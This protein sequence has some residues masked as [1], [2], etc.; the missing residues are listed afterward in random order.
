MK[1]RSLLAS[2]FLIIATTASAKTIVVSDIDDTLKNAHVLNT[3]DMVKN[4]VFTNDQFLGINWVYNQLSLS[5]PEM[6]FFYVSSAPQQIMQE[7]HEDFIRGNKF[8]RGGVYLKTDFFSSDF[9]LVKIRQILKQELPSDVIFVGDNGEI[10]TLVYE[11]LRTEFPT[12]KFTTYIHLAYYSKS[13]KET[14]K[15][16][17]AGQIGFATSLDL[18]LQLYQQNLIPQNYLQGFLDTF[19]GVYLKQNENDVRLAIANWMDCR[20]FSWTVN[21]SVFAESML[22][23]QLKQKIVQRCSQGSFSND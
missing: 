4:S 6:R 12:M 13:S 22:F 1:Y 14:G 8:A 16:L 17:V 9:K 23:S 21:D 11:Q 20:D 10:D 15:A 2:L 5:N 3:E 7:L 19:A 18:L